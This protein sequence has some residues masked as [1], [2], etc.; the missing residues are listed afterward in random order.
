MRRAKARAA[1]DAL[2]AWVFGTLGRGPSLGTGRDEGGGF[3]DA[4]APACEPGM[5]VDD[6][7]ADLEGD[8]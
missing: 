8:C 2:P 5:D 6:A 1:E 4:N 7:L 3:G